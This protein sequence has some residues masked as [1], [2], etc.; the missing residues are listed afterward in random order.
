MDFKID[1]DAQVT[2]LDKVE[3]LEEKIDKLTKKD[4]PVKIKPEVDGGKTGIDT[5]KKG[6]DGANQS[7][8]NLNA[9]FGQISSAKIKY[10]AFK[11]LQ[12]QAKTAYDEVKNLN[13]AMT[14]VNMT[15]LDMPKSSLSSLSEQAVQMAKDLSTYTETVTDAVTI[16]ANANESANSILAKAQ[17]T[18]LLAA[19]SG[20]SSSK[21]ADAIQGI[22]NQFNMADDQAMHVADSIEKLSSEIA[23]DFSKGIGT[24]SDAVSVGG[25]VMEEAGLSFEKYGAIVSATAEKTRT[26]GSTLGN[27]FKTIASRITRS[28][29]GEA[30]DEDR[31]KAEEALNSVGISIRGADGDFRDLSVTLDELHSKWDTLNK[32]QKSYVAEQAAGVRNKNVFLAMMDTYGRAM[33]LEQAAFDSTGT[34]MEINEKRAESINGKLQKLSASMSEMY[35]DAISEDAIKGM[36]DFATNITEVVDKL[37][38]LKGALAGIGAF[39]VSNIVGKLAANWETIAGFLTNPTTLFSVGIG[40]VV[41][42]VSAYQKQIQ[43]MVESARQAGTAWEESETSLQGQIDQITELRTA[44]DSGTLSEQEAYDAKSNLLSIQDNLTASYG[45]QVSEI[46]LLNGSLEKQISLLDQLS[47]NEANQFLNENKKGIEK[48]VNEI[49]KSRHAYL[50]EFS[51][52]WDGADKLQEIVDKYRNDGISTMTDES[53]GMITV[54]FNGDASKAEDVL[55][56][57]MTDVRNA[58]EETGNTDL[59]SGFSENASAGLN[60]AKGVLDEYQDLY[61]QAMKA[62]LTADPKQYDGKTSAKWL[63]D[64][65]SAVKEYN[66][67]LSEGDTSK[68]AEAKTAFDEVNMSVQSLLDNSDMS[69]YADQFSD[70]SAQLNTAAVAANEFNQAIAGEGTNGYQKHIKN[71]VDEIKSMDMDDIDFKAAIESGSIDSINYIS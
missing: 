31:A 39:S 71:I 10:D 46:N 56:S 8:K 47:Q 29:T 65:A 66:S 9:T 70:V 11:F 54:H 7:A 6:I 61:N 59:F 43:E 1:V 63:N 15:M 23:V 51:P 68:I 2:G 14:L 49:E 13:A 16:Y 4:H 60:E 57:F 44:L 55:N 35:K 42:G 27:A 30:S 32:S 21:A 38:L 12:Q 62:E 67:A 64:Y 5:L 41:A 33:E 28:K 40:A 17:P 19:A 69:K 58:S 25:S 52:Y 53:T 37:G 18:V 50:G 36:L 34:A 48:A 3:E 24:I 22:L 45:E 26:S 20:M